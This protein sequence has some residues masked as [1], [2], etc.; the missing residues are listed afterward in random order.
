MLP[1]DFTFEGGALALARGGGAWEEAGEVVVH[2][3]YLGVNA[4]RGWNVTHLALALRRAIPGGQGAGYEVLP[5]LSS[6]CSRTN[7]Y[8]WSPSPPEAGTSRT[9]SSQGGEDGT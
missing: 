3:P 6:G 9:R 2:A 5:P 1:V 7:S 4:G 8:P